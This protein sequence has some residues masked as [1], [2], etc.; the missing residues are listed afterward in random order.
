MSLIFGSVHYVHSV[1]VG[2]TCSAA[3]AQDLCAMQVS[4]GHSIGWELKCYTT[5]DSPRSGCGVTCSLSWVSIFR[6]CLRH[7]HATQFIS[8]SFRTW[9][10]ASSSYKHQY[11]SRDKKRNKSIEKATT[12]TH[13]SNLRSS[14]CCDMEAL[15]LPQGT[16]YANRFRRAGAQLCI[17]RFQ[18][19]HTAPIC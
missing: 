15:R 14:A 18:L 1:V 13:T 10:E 5:V 11:I 9:K 19:Q 7:Q 17:S 4:G 6:G 8:T 12:T 2:K 16:P 3:S